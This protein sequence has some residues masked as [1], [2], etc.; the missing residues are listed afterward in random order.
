MRL[1]ALYS[2]LPYYTLTVSKASLQVVIYKNRLKLS[3]VL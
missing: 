3:L 1:R 2:T